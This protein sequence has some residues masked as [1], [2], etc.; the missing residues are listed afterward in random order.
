MENWKQFSIWWKKK[1]EETKKQ[2][3]GFSPERA[4]WLTVGG[5]F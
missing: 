4:D 3:T 5:F 1:A 2:A